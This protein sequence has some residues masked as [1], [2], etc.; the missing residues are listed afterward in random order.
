M[1]RSCPGYS[2][3]AV[4]LLVM[5]AGICEAFNHPALVRSVGPRPG[6][7]GLVPS[8]LHTTRCWR[9]HPLLPLT[10]T[11]KSSESRAWMMAV[12]GTDRGDFRGDYGKDQVSRMSPRDCLVAFT[13]PTSTYQPAC[14]PC[15]RSTAV[16]RERQ[17]AASSALGVFESRPDE[18]I[19][20]ASNDAM[21]H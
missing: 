2:S 20:S 17:L 13:M 21:C 15:P 6:I 19:V 8:S 14:Q 4:I 7:D 18:H 11:K 12:G 3:C 10:F 9:L 5:A 1:A 16:T